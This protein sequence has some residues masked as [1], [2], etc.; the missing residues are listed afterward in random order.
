MSYTEDQLT[1]WFPAH[2]SP[3]RNGLYMKLCGYGCAIGFQFWDGE[4]WYAWHFVPFGAEM[5]YEG[6][7]KAAP[8]FDQWRGLN[9]NPTKQKG[10]K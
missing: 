7:R 2:V 5:A 8:V 4:C 6:G 3:A 10:V 1:P 9:F